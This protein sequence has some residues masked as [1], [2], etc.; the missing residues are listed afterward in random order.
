MVTL[1]WEP[2]GKL[3]R[4]LFTLQYQRMQFLKTRS[5]NQSLF[6]LKLLEKVEKRKWGQVVSINEKNG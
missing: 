6:L 3:I 1:T 5:L 2:M 4:H